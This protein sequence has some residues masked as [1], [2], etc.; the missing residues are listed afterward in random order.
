[1]LFLP[2]TNTVML[3][4]PYCGTITEPGLPTFIP[5][6]R[7]KTGALRGVI[8]LN[9]L[10]FLLFSFS[11]CSCEIRLLQCLRFGLPDATLNAITFRAIICFLHRGA[12]LADKCSPYRFLKTRFLVTGFYYIGNYSEFIKIKLKHVCY[13]CQ[14]T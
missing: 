9:G 13:I 5:G 6:K 10:D 14:L 12:Q 1:M 3:L 2:H 4:E 11:S 7:R 8:C